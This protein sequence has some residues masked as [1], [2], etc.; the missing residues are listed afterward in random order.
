M[1]LSWYFFCILGLIVLFCQCKQLSKFLN[2]KDLKSYSKIIRNFFIGVWK[3]NIFNI[4]LSFFN[5]FFSDVSIT[6]LDTIIWSFFIY[7][8]Y[9]L[10]YIFI[11]FIKFIVYIFKFF[12]RSYLFFCIDAFSYLIKCLLHLFSNLRLQFSNSTQVLLSII[13][14]LY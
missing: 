12:I 13:T 6:S 10:F 11:N 7:L 8:F 9:Y 4:S 2:C 14:Y 5:C 3:R 1:P